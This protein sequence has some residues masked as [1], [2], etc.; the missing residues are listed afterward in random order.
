MQ[1]KNLDP[2]LKSYLIRA[3]R[4]SFKR[5]KLYRKV[6]RSARVERVKLKKDGTPSKRPDVYYRCKMCSKLNKEK[7]IQVDHRDPVTS[8]HTSVNEL[9]I[10][11]YISKVYCSELNL[12]VLCKPCHKS[13]TQAENKI[14]KQIKQQK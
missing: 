9:T 13:K 4:D 3:I 12:Q 6:K 7:E 10:A 8:L 1:L 14:R 11:G 2:V 5:S